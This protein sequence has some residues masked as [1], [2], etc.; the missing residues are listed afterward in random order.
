MSRKITIGSAR[1][2]KN[3]SIVTIEQKQSSGV[4]NQYPILLLS[5]FDTIATIPS[6]EAIS[7]S[8]YASKKNFTTT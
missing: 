5:T 6:E 7:N 2:I 3:A 8:K 1:Q 4:L